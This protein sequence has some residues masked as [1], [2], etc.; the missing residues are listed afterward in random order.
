MELK[1]LMISVKNLKLSIGE[2][3]ELISR[4]KLLCYYHLDKVIH[5]IKQSDIEN[6]WRKKNG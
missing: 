5:T 2:N 3:K 6:S 1:M 4:E